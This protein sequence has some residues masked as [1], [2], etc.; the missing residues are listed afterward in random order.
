MF[1]LVCTCM[2][3][4]LESGFTPMGQETTW[5][6]LYPSGSVVITVPSAMVPAKISPTTWTQEGG[7]GTKRYWAVTS[8]PPAFVHPF[9][10]VMACHDESEI[11]PRLTVPTIKFPAGGTWMMYT[12]WLSETGPIIEVTRM[13]MV[14]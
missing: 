12:R 1:P 14:S 6:G 4:A 10:R 8:V 2:R 9:R 3:A 5:M 7:E 13:E 11:L